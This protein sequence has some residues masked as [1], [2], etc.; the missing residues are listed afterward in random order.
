MNMMDIENRGDIEVLVDAFYKK[1]LVD[2]TIGFI[3]NETVEFIWEEHI[4][5]M[6]D[7]RETILLHSGSYNRNPIKKH[8]E[9]N[10]K[11][12]LTE[13]HFNQWISLWQQT[14]DEHFKGAIANV[15]KEKAELMKQIMMHKI[16][17]SSGPNFI[18]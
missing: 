10:H 17:M 16:Q 14:I 7:F 6:Y 9:L 3:F 11:T 1:V 12:K 2:E 4:P 8:V 15:A 5:I 18:R 13:A